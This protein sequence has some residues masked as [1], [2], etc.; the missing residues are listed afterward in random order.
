MT[1]TMLIE[2]IRTDLVGRLRARREEI[3][4]ATLTRVYAL[5]EPVESGDA[6][7][8]HG[9]RAAVATALDYGIL[10]LQRGEERAPPVPAILLAQA[11]LAARGGVGLETVLRRYLAGY[12]VLGDFVIAEAEKGGLIQGPALRRMLRAQAATFDRLLG[13]VGDEYSREHAR[14][15]GSAEH[16]RLGRVKRLL[17][18]ELLDTADLAYEFGHHHLGLIA[19]GRAAAK[20]IRDLAAAHDRRLLMIRADES[21]IWAWLGSKRGFDAE[22][23]EAIERWQWPAAVSLAVGEPGHG[24]AGWRLTHRQAQAAFPSA[25]EA[26]EVV[27]RYADVALLASITRDDLLVAS[28]REMYLAPLAKGRDGGEVLRRTLRAYFHADRNGAS[29]AAALG[30]SRQTVQNRLRAAEEAIGRPLSTVATTLELALSLEDL[31][32]V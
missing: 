18:G 28:L 9:L 26:S 10:A 27:T 25:L 31:G 14:K 4:Q 20:T 30:I 22:E 17:E 21:V 16:R 23:L 12:T 13:A 15:S 6:E 7:Y 19:S 24:L 8:L 3:E 5:A 32:D 29:A 1:S 2:E 11:R